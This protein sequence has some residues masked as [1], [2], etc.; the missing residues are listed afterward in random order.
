MADSSLPPVP[1]IDWQVICVFDPDR[2]KPEFAYTV[3]LTGRGLPELHMWARPSE[4]SDPGEDWKFN[5]REL[6]GL[7]N[8]C[9]RRLIDEQ[10]AP[11]TSWSSEMDFGLARVDFTVGNPTPATSLE[12]N[13][14]APGAR[15]LPIRYAPHRTPRHR[16]GDVDAAAAAAIVGWA[17]AITSASGDASTG[18]AGRGAPAW[19]TSPGQRFGPATPVVGALRA[20]VLA[21]GPGQLADLAVFGMLLETG[22]P[23]PARVVLGATAAFGRVAGRDAAIVAARDAANADATDLLALPAVDSEL[24]DLLGETP[25]SP[26]AERSR[27]AIGSLV[28]HV[29]AAAYTAAATADVLR[30]DVLTAGLSP[31][32]TAVSSGR[33]ERLWFPADVRAAVRARLA[34][35]DQ[36]DLHRLAAAVAGDE[37]AVTAV[38]VA[39]LLAGSDCPPVEELLAGTPTLAAVTAAADGDT[40]VADELASALADV[41]RALAHPEVFGASRLTGL[42]RA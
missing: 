15:V 18:T 20:A 7:L 6:T 34:D 10:L 2:D 4:G 24:L 14:A 28:T 29:L 37:D 19:D 16:G 38:Q 23:L 13:L 32:L 9:A 35:L 39:A 41:A 17:E 30:G 1:A 33:V 12:A 3:G 31:V 27:H 5:P 25:W 36:T 11:G 8:S 42:L 40:Q 21:A 22:S 26:D